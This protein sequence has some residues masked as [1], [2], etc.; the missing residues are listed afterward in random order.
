MQNNATQY[1]LTGFKV[2]FQHRVGFIEFK[3]SFNAISHCFLCLNMLDRIVHEVKKVSDAAGAGCHQVQIIVEQLPGLSDCV[4]EV[5]AALEAVSTDKVKDWTAFYTTAAKSRV[6]WY[7][8]RAL[9][10]CFGIKGVQHHHQYNCPNFSERPHMNFLCCQCE[11]HQTPG[12]F[13]I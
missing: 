11:L 7:S 13:P 3:K 10:V 8:R 1:H 5:C 2:V 12:S 4:V 9:S 6:N